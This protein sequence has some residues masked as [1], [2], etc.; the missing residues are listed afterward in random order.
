[1]FFHASIVFYCWFLIGFLL[2][3]FILI[4]LLVYLFGFIYCFIYWGLGSENPARQLVGKTRWVF[5]RPNGF[6]PVAQSS[7]INRRYKPFGRKPLRLTEDPAGLPYKL[8]S[9]RNL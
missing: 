1:L 6:N 7:W 8:A 4:Y 5:R 2:V 9:R 3:L